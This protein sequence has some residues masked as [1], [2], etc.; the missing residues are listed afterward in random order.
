MTTP[1]VL[2]DGSGDAAYAYD[3]DCKWLITAP[4]GKKVHFRFTRLDTEMRRDMI[5]FFNGDGTHAP[6]MAIFSGQELP[7]ELTTWGNVVLVW[8]VT[9]GQNQGQG[10]EAEV[11]FVDAE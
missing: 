4:P 11:I 7:P 3:T 5:Y 10:W 6:I 8:F 1:G 2:S 9:D